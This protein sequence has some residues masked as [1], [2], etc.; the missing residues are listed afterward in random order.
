MVLVDLVIPVYNGE[1][2]IST[3]V[4]SLLKW[5]KDHIGYEWRI[6][7]VDNASTDKT[8]IVA[9]DYQKRYP[10]IVFVKHISRKGRGIALR[11]AWSESE[12]DVCAFMDVDLSTDLCHITEIIKPIVNNECDICCG[13]RWLSNSEVKRKFFRGILSWSYNFMLRV[14]LGLRINDAQ[15]GFKSIKTEVSHTIIPL[16]QDNSWFFDTELLAIA[17]KNGYRIKEIPVK[18]IDNSQTTVTVA[19]TIKEFL[20]GIW[21]LRLNGIPKTNRSK[22]TSESQSS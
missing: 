10:E 1:K 15:C 17:Q 13:S 22:N 2:D 8:L 19:R 11:T 16:V 6:V 7:I 12:A 21:R 3:C 14:F 18:W 9:N 5:I 4:D 20:K